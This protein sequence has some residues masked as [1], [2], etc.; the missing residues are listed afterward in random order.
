MA[1]QEHVYLLWTCSDCGHAGIPASPEARHCPACGHVRTFVEFDAAGL[2]GSDADWQQ[3]AHHPIPPE[4]VARLQAAGPNWFCTNCSADNYGDEPA[5]HHCKATRDASDAVLREAADF[6]TFEAYMK[7]DRG[8][9]ADLVE[10]FGAYAGMRAAHGLTFSM[11]DAKEGQLERAQQGRSAF[12]AE[13]QDER[14]HAS[15]PAWELADLPSA[16]ESMGGDARATVAGGGVG[17][18]NDADPLGLLAERQARRRKLLTLGLVAGVVLLLLVGGLVWAWL[19]RTEAVQ[20][21]IV[22]RTWEHRLE[23]QRWQPTRAEGWK[24]ELRERAE[25]PPAKGRAPVAGV[26]IG[27]CRAERHHDEPYVCGKQQ[28]PCQHLRAETE[29]YACSRNESYQERYACQKDESYA[30]GETCETARGANGMATRTCKPKMCVRKVPGECTRSATR[31]VPDRCTR[32]VN[33]PLHAFDTADKIC[34]RPV[35]AQR[36]SYQT[37]AWQPDGER[38]LQGKDA[39][40]WPDAPDDPAVRGVR[41]AR[42]RVV[43]GCPSGCTGQQT[44]EVDAATFAR[45]PV[46][47]TVRAEVDRHGVLQPLT[48]AALTAPAAAETR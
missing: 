27:A 23:L 26:A 15:R 24:D 1:S 36:C 29:T 28:V 14:H 42:Y 38:K 19:S 32:T 48:P 34:Q 30:C 5:C 20:A 45:L 22:D 47:A 6:E 37:Q 31:Q 10:Q 2:E 7:G 21:Q 18:D 12:S 46:G 33:K 39:P 3:Q 4:V 44:V 25:V 40:A 11:D 9:T 35:M 17:R 43:V 13:M 8:A 16:V 41:H